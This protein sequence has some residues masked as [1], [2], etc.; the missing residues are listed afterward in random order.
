MRLAFVAAFAFAVGVLLRDTA[1]DY[2][3]PDPTCNV[4]KERAGQ[5]AEALIF[6]LNRKT[7]EIG[8]SLVSCRVEHPKD[9]S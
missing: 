4:A 3:K 6:L 9:Q 7:I 2:A 8:G 5:Y 1:Q